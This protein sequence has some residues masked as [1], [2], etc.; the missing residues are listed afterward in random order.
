MIR[1]QKIRKSAMTKAEKRRVSFF[2]DIGCVPCYLEDHPGTP[3]DNAHETNGGRREGHSFTFPAC[4]WHHRGVT[5]EGMD[6]ETATALYGPS[7]AVSK[8]SFEARYGTEREL[9]EKTDELLAAYLK[10]AFS[11]RTGT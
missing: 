2:Q 5:P 10:N 8:K 3:A 11:W 4:P 7:F 6:S 1:S 9:V